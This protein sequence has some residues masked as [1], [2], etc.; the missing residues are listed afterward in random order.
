MLVLALVVV[1]VVVCYLFLQKTRIGK[2]IRAPGQN[3]TGAA[4]VGIQTTYVTSVVFVLVSA[5]AAAG[6]L[7]GSLFAITPTWRRL[8]S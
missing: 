5:M 4:L 3:R 1:L 7:Y 6:V 8:P 2:A